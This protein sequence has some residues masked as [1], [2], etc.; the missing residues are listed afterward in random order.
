[1]KKAQFFIS[2]ILIS[3][4]VLAQAAAV[5]A[6]P[7]HEESGYIIGN[8]Q[9][10]KLQTDTNTGT[11]TVVV[12]LKDKNGELHTVRL[13]V[14]VASHPDLGLV[15]LDEDG[16]PVINEGALG[17]QVGIDLET[18]LL[19]EKHPVGSALSTFFHVEYSS[20]ME[21]HE[22]GIGFG[23]LT[24][25]LWLTRKIAGDNA[26]AMDM[27]LIFDKV[28]QVKTGELSYESFYAT[29]VTNDDGTPIDEENIPTNWVEF[30]K[31]LLGGDKKVNLGTA[32]SSKDE[33]AGTGQSG[34]AHSN[35]D[36]DK[37]KSNNGNG[38]DNGNSG[39][40]NSNGNKP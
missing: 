12:T 17:Q 26:T 14:E 3:V 2:L 32:M 19:E 8:V 1:M 4:L 31:A 24:Q 30:R 9:K 25:A 40:G 34:N 15:T 7:T 21:Y 18:A 39:D 13:S 28:M 10:I 33:N 22:S 6:A 16:N 35:K 36:K 37:E 38:K 27:A 11:S 29:Y 20:I 23:V 5:L